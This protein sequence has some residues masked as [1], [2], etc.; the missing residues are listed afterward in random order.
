MVFGL[1]DFNSMGF[2]FKMGS[3]DIALLGMLLRQT[4]QRFLYWLK[5]HSGNPSLAE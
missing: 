1:N 3:L 4:M 2:F 5:R